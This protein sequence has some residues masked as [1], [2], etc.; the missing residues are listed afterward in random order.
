MAGEMT[1]KKSNREETSIEILH[2]R[3]WLCVQTNKRGVHWWNW[4]VHWGY[5]GCTIPLYIQ[6]GE[7]IKFRPGT[8]ASAAASQQNQE[9]GAP[10]SLLEKTV[11]K[12]QACWKGKEN[13]DLTDFFWFSSMLSH[14]AKLGLDNSPS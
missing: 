9:K 6:V 12:N 8:H 5:R 7:V 4:G 13:E 1:R 2:N 14:N 3:V 11:I 10:S